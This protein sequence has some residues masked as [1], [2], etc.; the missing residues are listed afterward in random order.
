LTAIESESARAE[1]L[2]ELNVVQ[3]VLNAAQTRVIRDAWARGQ[4]VT[5]HGWIYGLTDGL[6]RY[7]GLSI[8]S[9]EQLTQ[10]AEANWIRPTPIKSKR[11]L[12]GLSLA[13]ERD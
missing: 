5:V 13:R 7:L 6:V 10:A 9:L 8:S 3:Q 2:C 12:R 4:P 1:S 11:V